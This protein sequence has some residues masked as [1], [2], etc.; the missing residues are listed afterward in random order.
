MS[1]GTGL[2]EI[3]PADRSTPGS[4]PLTSEHLTRFCQRRADHLT[5][6]TDI[7][8]VRL[9]YQDPFTQHHETVWS[10]KQDSLLMP[11]LLNDLKSETWL[12]DFFPVLSLTQI[13]FQNTQYHGYFCPIGYKNQQPEY[14]FVLSEQPLTLDRQS[15]L[16]ETAA[17]LIEY[18]E[19]YQNSYQKQ[20]EIHLLEHIVHRVG[21]QLRNPLGLISLY[22]ETLCLSSNT[23]L[24]Q[25]QA[26]IIR[27]TV[28]QLLTNLTDL[29]Y[30]GQSDRLKTSLQDLQILIRESVAAFQPMIEQKQITVSYPNT[31]VLLQVDRLQIKQVLDNLLS[32]AIHFSPLN[33]KIAL[34][35]WSFQGEVLIQISD[36]GSGIPA[37]Q[38]QK[39]FE[40]FYTRR[41]GGTGLGLTIAKKIV[42]DHQGNLW[43]QSLPEGGARFSITLPRPLT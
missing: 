23:P 40:P 9:V 28:Q 14:L 3:A 7:A 8:L 19:L 10:Q 11:D 1:P 18:L 5:A 42:L 6:Q 37:D 17:F 43:A 13:P 39:I 27:D 30:C 31:A 26:G 33:G 12:L 35:W 15:Y 20:S 38:L 2:L 41:P 24:V 22:T 29:I 21:H 16:R 4:Q 32:N 25:E 34:N 36:Q